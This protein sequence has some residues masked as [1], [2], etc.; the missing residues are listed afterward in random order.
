V[1][2][3][4]PLLLLLA[5]SGMASAGKPTDQLEPGMSKDEVRQLLGAPAN[6]SFRGTDEAWQYQ[7][8][9]GFDQCKYTTV[10]IRDDKVVGLS[11]RRG[12]SVD[13]CALGSKDVVWSEMPQ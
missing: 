11:T 8:V 3:L 4:F 10:W 13:S 12:Q 6:R 2:K 5:L 9:S 7:E 1:L